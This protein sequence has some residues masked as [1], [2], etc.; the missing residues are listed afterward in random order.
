MATVRA[1]LALLL[2]AGVAAA[3]QSCSYTSSTGYFY[4]LSGM[5]HGSGAED[6]IINDAGSTF[7]VNVCGVTTAA[8]SPTTPMSVCQKGY[9][10]YYGAGAL[11]TQQ[12][13]GGEDGQGVNVWYG[14]G[15]L[16]GDGDVRNTLL[17]ISCDPSVSGA[18]VIDSTQEVGCNYTMKVR[19]K[20]ACPQVNNCAYTTP[21]GKYSYDLSNMTHHAGGVDISATDENG[22]K[23]YV[24][25]CGNTTA[26]CNPAM[27]VCQKAL[28]SLYYGAGTL[29]TQTFSPLENPAAGVAITYTDGT[30]CG[31]ST[32][33][34]STLRITC[35]PY[36]SGVG[37]IDSIVESSC[38]Y[39]LE[40][41]SQYACAN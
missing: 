27:S 3:S 18:G 20:Y 38:A 29:A 35:A 25:V 6:M 36:I 33:R 22:N 16:C 34:Q 17:K 1:A 8:C 40:M 21:D 30:A 28:N 9:N 12:F 37:V 5:T 31:T 11:F 15:T 24:N 39:T 41:R 26:A 10:A 19:S 14:D 2:V 13:S 7:F 32:K 23:F 4:D